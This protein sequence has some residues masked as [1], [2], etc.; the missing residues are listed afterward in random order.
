MA[1]LET[2]AGDLISASAIAMV[3]LSVVA[4]GASAAWAYLRGLRESQP[5]EVWKPD[6]NSPRVSK[7]IASASQISVLA[8]VPLFLAVS[9]ASAYGTRLVRLVQDREAFADD[10]IEQ[11]ND[12]TNASTVYSRDGHQIMK[13]RLV[14]GVAWGDISV[15]Q[16]PVAFKPYRVQVR[17]SLSRESWSVRRRLVKSSTG[18]L[19]TGTKGA[20]DREGVKYDANE[21]AIQI[22]P[23]IE[24]TLLSR[25]VAFPG[26]GI[27]LEL[28]S[29]TFLVPT[30][31]FANFV[32][33]GYRVKAA[34]A[35]YTPVDEPW[36]LLDAQSGLPGLLA[37]LWMVA[38][39]VAPWLLSI[40][41]VRTV[42]L[43]LKTRGSESS[44]T[45]D[46]VATCVALVIVF[47]A[48]SVATAIRNLIALRE[49]SRSPT[50]S[51][52]ATQSSPDIEV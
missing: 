2:P 39:A 51:I 14:P 6:K 47:L 46:A 5:T 31:I 17:E 26:S 50:A 21:T 29:F 3:P 23:R 33:L 1:E 15:D 44:W 9:Q 8:L 12:M 22:F 42:A 7:L 4:I 10:L 32:L 34:L 20:A 30:V 19:F 28:G 45:L 49:L 25:E 40:L 48:I 38:L 37:N 16:L 13:T 24:S 27:S 43:T 11:Y 18:V 36:L 35:E 52:A 41:M